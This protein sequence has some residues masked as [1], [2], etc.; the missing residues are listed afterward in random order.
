MTQMMES[1]LRVNPEGAETFPNVKLLVLLYVGFQY[2]L[3]ALQKI[4]GRNEIEE[5]ISCMPDMLIYFDGIRNLQVGD[6]LTQGQMIFS[7]RNSFV[8]SDLLHQGENHTLNLER[9][10]EPLG[11][12]FITTDRLIALVEVFISNV[13]SAICDINEEARCETR[14]CEDEPTDTE[15]GTKSKVSKK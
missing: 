3:E 9:R 6:H 13:T 12:I 2:P 5:L 8:H 1:L 11:Q 15:T 10:R 7:I 14:H 4:Y